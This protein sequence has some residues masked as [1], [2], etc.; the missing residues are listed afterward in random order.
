MNCEKC[1]W[2]IWYYGMVVE[3]RNT[4]DC[5]TKEEFEEAEREEC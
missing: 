5:P 3:C 2:A 1:M 4:G